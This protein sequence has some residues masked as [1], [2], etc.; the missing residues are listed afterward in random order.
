MK[1]F[2]INNLGVFHVAVAV[3]IEKNNQIL[4]TKRS[5]DRDHAPNEWEAGI[6]GR[7]NQ[8]E[9]CEEAALRETKEELG[10]E[11]ELITAFKTFHF[12]RGKEQVEH[13]GVNF[14]AKY[15]SGDIVLD[16]SEQVEYKWV[17]PED[18]LNYVTDK[19][20]IEEVKTF[21]EFKK[22]YSL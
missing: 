4:I 20:V 16:T 8:G 14:W 15:I 7:V 3:V 19:S 10:I 6:T 11:V 9:T 18:A 12:Y 13:Q 17:T 22:H 1:S 21:I 5:P 2:R